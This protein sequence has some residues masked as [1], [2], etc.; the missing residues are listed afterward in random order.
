MAVEERARRQLQEAL[1]GMIGADET[2]TLFDHYLPPTGWAGVATKQDLEA[3][4]A[5]LSAKID[6]QGS[7]LEG[8]IDRALR[9][10][11]YALVV[12]MVALAGLAVGFLR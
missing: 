8:K 4:G 3:L 10:Q 6:A 7:R 9:T 11:F 5:S 12:I 1:M 2:D